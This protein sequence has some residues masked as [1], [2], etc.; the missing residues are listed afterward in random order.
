VRCLDILMIKSPKA[1][2]LPIPGSLSEPLA[3]AEAGKEGLLLKDMKKI[4]RGR[5][6]KFVFRS[7][8]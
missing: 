1:H 4:L 8:E 5:Q 2:L 6:T 7:K 3:L